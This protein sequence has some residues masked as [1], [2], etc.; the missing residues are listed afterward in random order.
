MIWLQRDKK[1]F[2][3]EKRTGGHMKRT[4]IIRGKM[5]LCKID[6][7]EFIFKKILYESEIWVSVYELNEEI[8]N[9][10]ELEK[11]TKVAKLNVL[12]R[13]MLN[14]DERLLS[15]VSENQSRVYFCSYIIYM[16]SHSDMD[17]YLRLREMKDNWYQAS[18][19]KGSLGVEYEGEI[20]RSGSP[21]VYQKRA[22]YIRDPLLTATVLNTINELYY[23]NIVSASIDQNAANDL[24]S[25]LQDIHFTTAKVFKVGN[26]NLINLNGINEKTGQKFE[27]MY[28]VGYHHKEHPGDKRKSYGC[29][30]RVFGKINPNIV[31][32]SHWDD[33]HILGCV[34]SKRGLFDCRWV[35]PEIQKNAIG[36]R[37]LA[38]YLSVRGKLTLIK[39]SSANDRKL[40]T[41]TGKSGEI[42]FYL[43]Q[44]VNKNGL[45]KENCGGLVIEIINNSNNGN[46][47][48]SLF[49]GDV[50]YKAIE[51]IIWSQRTNGYDNLVV[52]H[53]GSKMNYSPMKIKNGATAVICCNNSKN[54]PAN[55]HRKALQGVLG[56]DAYVIK[57]TELALGCCIVLNLD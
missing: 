40:I 49:C 26:G 9:L 43:G 55:E 34:Y 12:S 29:A 45:S 15:E 50:P 46:K 20:E 28:D 23:K 1:S 35:A 52:P 3:L 54:R 39:R 8:S 57:L 17:A 33:D 4:N 5:E 32:L 27:A 36:A 21:V 11:P 2:C 10:T 19:L 37:R 24:A 42:S 38:A 31:L 13:D 41:I 6:D 25:L 7:L 53:H 14:Y 47:I 18:F 16:D 56:K 51:N 48:E 44:N 30:V 22:I